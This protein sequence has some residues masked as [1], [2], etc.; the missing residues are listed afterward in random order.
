ME[1][2]NAVMLA[3][4]RPAL[5]GTVLLQLQRTN[6]GLFEEAI[7]YYQDNIR[8]QD[9]A[10]MN[11]IIPCR[12]VKY[13]PPLPE[14][15]F[16]K[17]RF[18][19]FSALMFCRYEM[20]DYLSEFETVTWLDTDILVQSDLRNMIN[21]AKDTGAAFIR[22]D[23]D[24]KTATKPDYMRT[25]FSRPVSGYKMDEYLYCSGTIVL[26]RKIL[27]EQKID[28]AKC[29]DW[30]YRKTVHWANILDLP[31]QGVLNAAIQE[32][33]IKVSPLAE[34]KTAATQIWVEIV[35]KPRLFMRGEVTN[36]GMIGIFTRISRSGKHT[37]NRGEVKVGHR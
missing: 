37:M 36:F 22:E 4:T 6:P 3:D 5:V 10:L 19:R 30:C 34:K 8:E 14:H 35:M 9:R 32:F 26:S 13:A 25:C 2:R 17:P 7:I 12:F 15:L 16:E 31:D 20:F 27:A 21:A 11:A 29:T 1:K 23:P 18:K 24:N 28:G 33:K